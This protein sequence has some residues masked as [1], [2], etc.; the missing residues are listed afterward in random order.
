MLTNVSTLSD[1]WPAGLLALLLWPSL[2]LAQSGVTPVPVPLPRELAPRPLPER[3]EPVLLPTPPAPTAARELA[4]PDDERRIDVRGFSVADDAPAELRAALAGLTA[5]YVGPQRRFEDLQNAAAEVARF[6]QR[7]LGY[8]LGYAYIPEQTSSDGLVRIGV[9]EGRLDEVQLRWPDKLPVRR[10]VIAAY[11]A[12]LKPGEILRVRELERVI[13]LI[14]DLRGITARFEVQAGSRPGTARL[15]VTPAAEPL[16]AAKAEADLNGSRFFGEARLSGLAQWNSPLGA[17]DGLTANAL[18]TSTAA[19]AFGLVSYTRPIGASGLKLGGGLSLVRYKLKEDEFPLGLSGTAISAN[20]YA[21]YPLV[22]SRNWNLF[23][24]GSLEHK[25]Y[26]DKQA[27]AGTAIKKNTSNV[28]LGAT[29]DFRDSLLGGAVNTYELQLAAGQLRYGGG[30][31]AGNLDAPSYQKATAGFTRLQNLFTNRA[32]LYVSLRGQAAL[33]NLDTTEQFRVGGPEGVRAYAPGEG[34]GDSG[35]IATLEL[36]WLPPESIFGRIGRESVVALFADWGTVTFRH[37]PAPALQTGASA[38][39]ARLA[40]A[41]IGWTWVRP[42]QFALRTS[43]ATPLE[44]QARND[45]KERDPRLYAQ[46]T[47][48]FD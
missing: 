38:N 33:H 45:K 42:G 20:G 32:L 10:E 12:Q 27:V 34:T 28:L 9:L 14:N 4:R 40:G 26:T 43:L 44:G 46:F 7:E 31:T 41:G 22:R 29:G 23:T 37:E 16:W 35:A 5:A 36:R 8:Y 24:I 47:M 6:L 13:F 25:L 39:S 18:I 48:F 30:F 21:V 11:L 1:S 2:A 15:V 17:G 3:A 19:M